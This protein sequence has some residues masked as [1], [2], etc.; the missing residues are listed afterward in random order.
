[1][2]AE[3]NKP[4]ILS[5]IADLV[6]NNSAI[7]KLTKQEDLLEAP[8]SV[9]SEELGK[10]LE[11]LGANE[12]YRDIK[13]IQGKKT[14]YMFSEERMTRNYALMM[15][16]TEDADVSALI[17]ETVREESKLYPRP[18]DIR[19]FSNNPFNLDPESAEKAYRKLTKKKEYQDIKECRASN[20]ALYLYSDMY[21]TKE[22][23]ESL[24][25]W[26]EVIQPQNP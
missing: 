23:A 25:E 19:F 1:M 5:M 6:R 4:D 2:K 15:A 17:A 26:I 20:G 18:T 8:L 21:L 11:E 7:P 14:L 12:L 9:P 13:Y 16:R 24:T 10:K 22:H 3:E